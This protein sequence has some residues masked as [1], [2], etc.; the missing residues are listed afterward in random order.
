MPT[1]S[2]AS[3]QAGP[4]VTGQLIA[5]RSSHGALRDHRMASM[6]G[7]SFSPP[8]PA[9]LPLSARRP[10]PTQTHITKLCHS[11]HGPAVL[12]DIWRVSV[13]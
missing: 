7:F 13:A 2:T 10:R 9:L 8:P 1:S 4:A 12:R 5:D 6:C 3:E 11:W